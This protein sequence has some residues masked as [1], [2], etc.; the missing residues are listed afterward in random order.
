MWKHGMCFNAATV[1]TQL[2]FITGEFIF[3]DWLVCDVSH[4]QTSLNCFSAVQTIASQ[5]THIWKQKNLHFISLHIIAETTGAMVFF[6]PLV[7]GKQ[8][9]Q[10]FSLFSFLCEMHTHAVLKLF[11]V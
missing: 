8:Q 1:M 4:F 10:L 2:K 5:C 9:L 6:C 7:V 11:K 3:E